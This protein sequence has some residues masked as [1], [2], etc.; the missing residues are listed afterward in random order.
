MDV[1]A[2]TFRR[3]AGVLALGHAAAGVLLLLSC[4]PAAALYAQVKPTL[5]VG[6]DCLGGVS[7]L[8]PKLTTC[9]I[10]GTKIRIWCPNGQMYEGAIEHGGPQASI[11]RS[12]CNMSQVP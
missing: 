5:K 1:F 3:M 6:N 2:T 7:V 11:A 4:N 8:A 10:A 12:L 9:T